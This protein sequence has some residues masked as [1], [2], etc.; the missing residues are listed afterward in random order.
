MQKNRPGTVTIGD[1]IVEEPRSEWLR[2]FPEMRGDK[3]KRDDLHAGSKLYT[4]MFASG[5]FYQYQFTVRNVGD[6]D[7]TIKND[8]KLYALPVQISDRELGK[9]YSSK[10]CVDVE[11]SHAVP[12]ESIKW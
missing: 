4:I 1:C 3:V 8:D 7:I 6:N 10:K 5:S 2:G 12:E 11:P 9:Y